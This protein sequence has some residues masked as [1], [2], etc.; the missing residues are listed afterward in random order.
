MNVGQ[1]WKIGTLVKRILDSAQD[2]S[3]IRVGHVKDHDADGMTALAAERTSE[4]VGA[5]AELFGRDF[6]S[7]LCR[8]RDVAGER[9]IVQDD[10]NRG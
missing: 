6:D 10:G 3:A 8:R 7:F 5:I 4:K 2:Q 9:S 1:D